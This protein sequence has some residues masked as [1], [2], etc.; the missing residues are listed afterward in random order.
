MWQWILV[1][2]RSNTPP[3]RRTSAYVRQRW[4]DCVV[5]K[6]RWLGPPEGRSRCFICHT[7]FTAD[8]GQRHNQSFGGKKNPKRH[9]STRLPA[10]P[11]RRTRDEV[12]AAN[13]SSE[14]DDVSLSPR[15]LTHTPDDIDADACVRVLLPIVDRHG[16]HRLLLLHSA[17]NTLVL[18]APRVAL[19][20]FAL[21]PL[22]PKP[23]D[24]P[25]T[26]F[27][28]LLFSSIR[29]DKNAHWIALTE[30]K[31]P[32][33]YEGRT[34]LKRN[35]QRGGWLGSLVFCCLVSCCCAQG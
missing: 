7:F 34:C 27:P 18:L 5:W 22:S 19:H 16:S 6:A 8:G 11:Q 3:V 31:R 12:S 2:D 10:C 29:I 28:F 32:P 14:V 23:C 9:K 24:L 15:E 17:C 20:D 33:S 35:R 13:N 1:P 25:S 26:L 4:V 21:D 30:S